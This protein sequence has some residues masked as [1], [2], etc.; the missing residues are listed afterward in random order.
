MHA[1]RATTANRF[2]SR[3]GTPTGFAATLTLGLP[4]TVTAG[5]QE[6]QELPDML[7]I[8]AW[9][10]DR[11]GWT[12]AAPMPTHRNQLSRVNLDGKTYAHGGQFPGRSAVQAD[13]WVGRLP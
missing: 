7:D 1:A 12:A 2:R 6:W 9:A 4:T 13:M 8:D 5:A 10:L 3:P 11:A